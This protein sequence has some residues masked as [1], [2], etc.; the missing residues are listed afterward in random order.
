M[1]VKLERIVDY[2]ACKDGKRH[3][4]KNKA[5]DYDSDVCLVCGHTKKGVQWLKKVQKE[6]DAFFSQFV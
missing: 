4:W 5:I 2:T 3:I 1:S 6:A